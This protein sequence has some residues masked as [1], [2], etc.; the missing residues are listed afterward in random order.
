VAYREFG[1]HSRAIDVNVEVHV[2]GGMPAPMSLGP[3]RPTP[4]GTAVIVIY[5]ASALLFLALPGAVSS[6]LD[7]LQPNL[8]V[9]CAKSL[10]QPVEQ[11]SERIGS[12]YVYRE[13]RGA[14]LR[15]A[16]QRS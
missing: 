10:V 3:A 6:W 5:G 7:D 12:A 14:F 8:V 11:I 13:I 16:R 15:I 4:L 2:E 9:E 1:G